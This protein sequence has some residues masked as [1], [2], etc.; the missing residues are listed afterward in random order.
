M[1]C[2]KDNTDFGI[3]LGLFVD[4]TIS[5]PSVLELTLIC[6]ITPFVYVNHIT[7]GWD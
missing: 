6:F 4:M 5:E 3:Q 2:K 7:N 1:T